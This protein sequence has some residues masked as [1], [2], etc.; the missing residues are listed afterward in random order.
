MLVKAEISQGYV[1]SLFRLIKK[2]NKIK[3]INIL[4]L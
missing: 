4:F 3:I 1:F 2:R